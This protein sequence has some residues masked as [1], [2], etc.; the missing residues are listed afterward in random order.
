CVGNNLQWYDSCGN[1]EDYSACQYGCQNNTCLGGET[2]IPPVTPPVPTYTPATF[3]LSKTVRNLTS[4]SGFSSSTYANPGDMLL[5]MV[6]LQSANNQAMG[7]VRITDSGSNGL[8]YK[9]QLTVSGAS[10]TGNMSS[11]IYI[12]SISSNQTVTVTYQAQVAPASY[13]SYGTTT[14]TNNVSLTSSGYGYNQTASAS[15]VVN[16]TAIY[17]ATSISTG[18]TN[19]FLVDSFLLPLLAVL[20]GVWLW[21]SGMFFGIEKWFSDKK[22]QKN[23]NKSEK[24]LSDRVQMIREAENI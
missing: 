18:L 14:L 23:S 11:G 17:G 7:N 16:K 6:T 1:Q 5:F 20:I 19:N 9:D 15:V 12:N 10:Y 4:G 3:T 22:K 8:I 24:E 2:N 13:F 21:K